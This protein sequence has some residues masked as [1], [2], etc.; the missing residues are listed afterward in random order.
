MYESLKKEK[1]SS[2]REIKVS[3]PS[4]PSRLTFLGWETTRHETWIIE[5]GWVGSSAV[6][7]KLW[8][9]LSTLPPTHKFSCI[10]SHYPCPYPPPPPTRSVP[11]LFSYVGKHFNLGE[12]FSSFPA[13][14][15]TA[16]FPISLPSHL[17]NFVIFP[18]TP[19]FL[20]SYKQ[21][22]NFSFTK[23]TRF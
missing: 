2:R 1:I 7:D 9:S 16:T 8:L 13:A 19:R 12:T 23:K 21:W 5:G 20:M 4:F 15:P 3:L 11:Y 10:S 22:W 14:Y 18:P 17:Y 6:G